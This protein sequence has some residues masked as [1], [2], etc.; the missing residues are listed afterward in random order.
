VPLISAHFGHWYISG[1]VYMSPVVLLV[2]WSAIVQRRDRRR[3]AREQRASSRPTE[4]PE[5]AARARR[6][7]D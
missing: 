2:A 4:A 1:P 3:A 7:S 6:R 5:V